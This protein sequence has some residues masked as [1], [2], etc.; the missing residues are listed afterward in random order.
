MENETIKMLENMA[1]T[2]IDLSEGTY[3]DVTYYKREIEKMKNEIEKMKNRIH[4]WNAMGS[5]FARAINQQRSV[6]ADKLDK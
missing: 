6:D 4:R 2:M 1:I 3:G 5:R